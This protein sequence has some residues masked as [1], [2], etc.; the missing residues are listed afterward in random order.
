MIYL[1]QEDERSFYPIG[2]QYLFAQETM[3]SSRFLR[4][5]NSSSL[6]C[7]LVQVGME[8]DTDSATHFEPSFAIQRGFRSLREFRNQALRPRVLFY[9]RPIHHDRNLYFTGLQAI[10]QFLQSPNEADTEVD[11]YFTGEPGQI[12]PRF[13][14][15]RTPRYL[16][17]LRFEEYLH[18]VSSFDVVLSLMASPHPSYPPLDALALGCRVVTNSWSGKTEPKEFGEGLWMAEPNPSFLAAALSQALSSFRNCATGVHVMP[19]VHEKYW[20]SWSTQFDE[21]LRWVADRIR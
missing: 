20:P 18:A 15:G 10:D 14:S 3:S 5:V 9:A 12:R 21:A 1:I 8:L 19:D 11:V 6:Y 13:S 17:A 16:G 7:Y 4:L 2:D